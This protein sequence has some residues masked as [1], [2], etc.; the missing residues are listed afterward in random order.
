MRYWESRRSNVRALKKPRR[1][2]KHLIASAGSLKNAPFLRQFYQHQAE[3]SDG[4]QK[5]FFFLILAALIY[6]FVLGDGGAVRIIGL[7]KRQSELQQSVS[8]LEHK[9]ALLRSEI[10]HMK[11]DPFY[12]EE[13]GRQY[14]YVRE[15]ET[16][17]KLIPLVDQTKKSDK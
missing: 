4:L 5:F 11:S 12:L 9:A 6:A 14:G 2:Q 3:I 10:D 15:G 16:V 17:Y 8:D 1:R 7:K 13:L